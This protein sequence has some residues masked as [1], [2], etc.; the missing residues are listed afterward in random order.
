MTSPTELSEAIIASLIMAMGLVAIAFAA[1]RR[2]SV[3]RTPF[4]FGLFGCLYAVRLA[5]QSQLVQPVLAEAHWRYLD[6]CITY[7]IIVPGG[8]FIES[9]L[10]PGWRRTLRRAWQAVAVYAP[11]AMLNDVWLRQPGAALWLNPPVVLTAGFIVIAHMLALWWRGRWPRDFRVVA[12][13][14]LIFLGVAAHRTLFGGDQL[15]EPLAMLVFMTAVGYFVAQR[16]L[17]GERRLVAVSREL[18]LAREIQQSILPRALPETAGLRVAARY[19]P[20]GDIGGDFYDFDTQR[21]DRLGILVAD[22]TGTASRRHW[23]LRW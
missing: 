16:M 12:A 6:A 15:G 17:A 22:V 11:L 21:A 14:G 7:A 5:G 4:W 10:G 20:M 23:W 18:D 2:P 1:V 19:L 3:D 13:G 9:V 8:L